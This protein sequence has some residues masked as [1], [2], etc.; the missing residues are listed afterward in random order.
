M[1]KGLTFSAALAEARKKFETLGI[2]TPDIDARL[3]LEHVTGFT[4]SQLISHAREHIQPDF[5]AR[6]DKVIKRRMEGEPVHRITGERDFYGRRFLLSPETLIPRPDTE[7]LIDEALDWARSHEHVLHVLDVGTGSGVIG[8]TL[9]AELEHLSLV[10]L[11]VSDGAIGAARRNAVRLA[12]D[13]RTRFLVSDM[14]E[15]VTGKFDLIVSN[16]PYIPTAD[17][18]GLDEIVREHDP[19]LALDGGDDGFDFYRQLFH[20]APEYM[21]EKASLFIEFGLGQRPALEHMAKTHGW[22]VD[23]VAKDLAGIDRVM[24]LSL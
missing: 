6:F 15:A 5:L 20:Q 14:F 3:L 10:A 9:L 18:S 4:H 22:Q 7:V 2:K 16:P 8:L 21:N 1:A 11:D 19:I 12:V 13:D 23:R 17:L 24:R